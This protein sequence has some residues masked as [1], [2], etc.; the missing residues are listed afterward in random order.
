MLDLG[1]S[2]N[3]MP[4]KVMQQLGLTFTRSYKNVCVMDS[5]EI[6]EFGLIK[7]LHV[8]FAVYPDILI[9]MDF[10]VIDVLDAWG[11]LSRK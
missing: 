4:L 11:M 7:D 9:L 3:V 8:K 5:R 1:A 10:V 2:T 6:K